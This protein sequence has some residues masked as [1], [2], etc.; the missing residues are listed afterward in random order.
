MKSSKG[1]G[2]SL[3]IAFAIFGIFNTVVFLAPLARTVVFWL[4]YFFA[5]FALITIA[6]TLVLYFGKPVKE[7]KFLSLP[8]V[9]VSWTYFVL[10]M[11]LSIWEMIAFPLPYLLAL[12]INLVV[13]AV[14]AVVVLALYATAGR[15]DKAEQFTAEKVLFIKQLKLKLD[16]IETDN[17]DLVKKVKELAEDV[18]FSDQMS[19][20]KLAEIESELDDVVDALVAGVADAEN[21]LLLCSKIEKLLKIRNEQCKMY[22]GVKDT[23]AAQAQK[24]ENGLGIAFAG[25]CVM[26]AMFLITLSVC[27]IVVPK[28]KYNE[29]LALFEAEKY[30]EAT[31]AFDK[32][33]DYSDSK[34]K[35]EEI[36]IIL[37][38]KQYDNAVALLEVEKYD[39]ATFAFTELGEYRDSKD[40][41][42]EIRIILLD[43]QYNEAEKLF[44]AGKYSEAINIYSALGD[45]KDSKLRVEQVYNR[46]SEGDILYFGTYNGEPIAWKI[47]K[48]E[49]DKML[50]VTEKPIAQKPFHDEI[51]KVTWETS[52]IRTWLNNEFIESF[53]AEQQNQIL[54]TDTGDTS[55]KVFLFSVDEMVDLVKKEKITFKTS[56]E[57]WTRTA[58]EDGIMY[59]TYKGWVKADG[60]QVV[61]DKGVRPAIWI[62][63][64]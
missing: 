55:D 33:G 11:G 13:G 7:D 60:D 43:K 42:E 50:L 47:L 53:S 49:S 41:V 4:G 22:K 62:D 17:V 21:A 18:R 2:I 24:S 20:S 3:F 31:V 58:S 57:W 39:E 8:A 19:H 64:R 44:D 16:S 30:G 23:V 51:K 59:A 52:Y 56:D 32:L 37:L 12:I 25:V 6:L 38:D 46:L 9:K 63:L 5:L 61:R 34:E 48:T 28:V 36:K 26:L 10:Q 54:S 15:I 1:Q 14:F 40:K 27:F 45:Y 29:A 35:I